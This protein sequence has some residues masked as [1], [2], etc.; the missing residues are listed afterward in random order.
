MN[1]KNIKKIY[2]FLADNWKT[3]IV[4]TIT[5]I[6]T[7]LMTKKVISPE[8]FKSVLNNLDTIGQLFEKNEVIL[9]EHEMLDTIDYTIHEE[10]EEKPVDWLD[11]EFEEPLFPE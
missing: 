11:E 8:Q 2:Q 10:I 1:P 4:V 7:F 3:S 9:H 6:L 5:T